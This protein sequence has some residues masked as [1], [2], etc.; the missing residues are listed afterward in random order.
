[1]FFFFHIGA[2]LL[3]LE[4]IRFFSSKSISIHRGGL[5]I[6]SIFPD[7]VDKPIAI[8]LGGGGRDFGHSPIILLILILFLYFI[9]SKEIMIASLQD[10]KK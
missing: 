5:I 10:V 6:G 8:F 3:V 9:I 2:P 1:M 7:L 4:I